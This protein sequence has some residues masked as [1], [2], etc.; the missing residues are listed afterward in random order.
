MAAI[1]LENEMGESTTLRAGQTL[2]IPTTQ[3]WEGSSPFWIVHVVKPGETLIGIAQAYDLEAGSL[4]AVNGL[5]DADLIEVGQTLILPLLGPVTAVEPAPTVVPEP[6]L[7]QE[8]VEPSPPGPTASPTVSNTAVAP[9]TATV[10]LSPTRTSSN[11]APPADLMAWPQ[12][13]LSLINQERA[14]QGLYP[15]AYNADL[16]Q[17]AQAHAYDCSQRGWCSHTGSDGADI[18]T[19]ISRRGYK[20]TGWAE[21]WAQTQSPQRAVEVWMD[22]TPPNDPHRRTLLTTWLTEIGIGVAEADWGNY[23]IADFGRP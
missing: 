9:I 14:Q 21:C 18:K 15:L 3:E 20:A 4:Q 8:T 7:T 6:T 10:E 23:I 17:A 22:E 2:S 16:E 1:Q 13:I 12:Q 19:R 5:G 11:A